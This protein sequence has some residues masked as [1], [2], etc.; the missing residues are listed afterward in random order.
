MKHGPPSGTTRTESSTLHCITHHMGY[1]D[2]YT[3]GSIPTFID[4]LSVW[5]EILFFLKLV[6]VLYHQPLRKEKFLPSH[7]PLFVFPFY[8]FSKACGEFNGKS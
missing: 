1:Y 4:E 8:P 2:K 7:E 6:V 5:V 3:Y